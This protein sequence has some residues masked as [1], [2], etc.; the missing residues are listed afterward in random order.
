MSLSGLC[1]FFQ[2]TER[3]LE[4]EVME[5]AE[6]VRVFDQ[7][8][9]AHGIIDTMLVRK[10]LRM[11]LLEGGRVLD[12][13]CGSGRFAV[14]L[15][16]AAPDV[17]V[18]AL[19]LSRPMLQLAERNALQAGVTNLRFV[20][21]DAEELPFADG[22]FRLVVSYHMLHH[23]PEPVPMLREMW[24]V[25]RPGGTVFVRDLARPPLRGFVALLVSVLGRVYDGLDESAEMGRQLYRASLR[26]ALGA[27]EWKDLSRRFGADRGH[28]HAL[29]LLSHMDMV[30]R[31]P[32]G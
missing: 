16:R 13:G 32:G 14:K 24:R 9:K 27:R 31:I 1:E 19:D 6:S 21:G 4:P 11:G 3:Q 22:E 20:R 26:A 7:V 17:D 12:V 2:P 30:L 8:A 23:L 15:A 29:P 18:V 10:L 5:D 25:T 28:L